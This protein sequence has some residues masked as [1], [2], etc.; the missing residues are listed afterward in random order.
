MET[1]LLVR[2]ENSGESP[3]AVPVSTV[4]S[5][6]LSAEFPEFRGKR[7]LFAAGHFDYFSGAE[8]Q[9]VY[10]AGELVKQLQA[11]VKFIGWG[12]NGRFADEIRA[13]GACPIVF[14]YNLD[15]SLWQNRRVLI[16]LARSVRRDLAPDFLLPYV[17]P[18]CRILGL[19]W[20]WTGAS[21]CW[22][23]QRDE[24]RGITGTLLD[25]YLIR[26]LP[27][28]ISN[29]WEGRDFLNKRFRLA[30]NRVKVIN[31]GVA[32]PA[33]LSEKSWRKKTGIPENA[34]VI[35]MIAT[36]SRF[37]D[38][39]TLMRAFAEVFR[40]LPGRDLRLIL[41]G[42][43]GDRLNHVRSVSAELNMEDSIL[44]PGEVTDI[45]SL[46]RSTDLVVHSSTTEGCPNG[47]LEPMAHGLC[48]L[49]TDISG[50]R[51]A[52]GAETAGDC[53]APPQDWRC[54]AEKMLQ[55]IQNP[56]QR[57]A[58]GQRNRQRIRL[59]FSISGMAHECLAAIRDEIGSQN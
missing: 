49:G 14:P 10:F 5:R 31:N 37:K 18:H 32:L 38:H 11:D 24:G 47:V 59:N 21:F 41:A 27:A 4:D 7:F 26:S 42:P 36:L 2:P 35:S 45:E 48:V 55:R 25:H 30:P 52:L 29:S 8:R 53:L 3:A 33:I 58:E 43:H 15:M 12:G 34:F 17:S 9:A 20:P 23:N 16:S 46:I 1:P 39:E 19:I 50:L 44:T 57:F 22:W 28:I 51:Q 40:R 56:E 13:V 6:S 54:L